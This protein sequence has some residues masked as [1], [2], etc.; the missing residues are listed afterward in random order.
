MSENKEARAD[1]EIREDGDD[2]L[3]TSEDL[4]TEVAIFPQTKKP[5]LTLVGCFAMANHEKI[6][7]TNMDVEETDMSY[8]VTCEG[9]TPDGE[10][11]FGGHEEFKGSNATHAYAKAISKAQRNLFKAFLYGNATVKEAF[12]KF[13]VEQ[14]KKA[15]AKAAGKQ[16]NRAKQRTPIEIPPPSDAVSLPLNKP[17]AD[18]ELKTQSEGEP[19][20][21]SERIYS[22]E[23]MEGETA[24]EGNDKTGYYRRY[25]FAL[26]NEHQPLPNGTGRLPADFWERVKAKYGVKSRATMTAVQWRDCLSMISDLLNEDVGIGDIGA[27]DT[28]I[29]MHGQAKTDEAEGESNSKDMR[30]ASDSEIA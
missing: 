21:E 15:E 19:K 7:I 3:I 6:T 8:R 30:E 14:E 13:E 20:K 11:R 1:W 10:V 24:P 2:N 17:H 12:A 22:V 4:V 9:K 27:S 25:G 18:A 23:E 26:W 16:A 28:D 5:Y 29:E